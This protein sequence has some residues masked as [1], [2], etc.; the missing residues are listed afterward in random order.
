MKKTP[1]VVI[2][3][4][5]QRGSFNNTINKSKALDKL[6][7]NNENICDACDSLVFCEDSFWNEGW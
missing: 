3:A 7:K 6:R 1:K 4:G 2:N 5:K